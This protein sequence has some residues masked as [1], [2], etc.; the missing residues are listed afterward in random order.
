[1]TRDEIW[2][3]LNAHIDGELP[4]EA[5]VAMVRALERDPALARQ[6]ARLRQLK[7]G[8]QRVGEHRRQE[9]RR[10]RTKRDGRRSWPGWKPVT[11]WLLLVAMLVGAWP[12]WRY[13]MPG[14]QVPDEVKVAIG[15]DA[16]WKSALASSPHEQPVDYPGRSPAKRSFAPFIPDLTRAGFHFDSMVRLQ[17][18]RS[19]GLHVGYLGRHGC[20]VSLVIFPGQDAADSLVQTYDYQQVRVYTW[21]VS[22]TRYYLLAPDMDPQRLA[23]MA[24]VVWRLIR[25]HA[26][27]DDLS[28]ALLSQA[29]R[30]A[31]PC[32]A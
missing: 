24:R 8:L 17:S 32:S 25:R 29:R 2:R 14:K 12:A 11:L 16:A 22:H 27:L 20:R 26:P 28:L 31:M 13:L 6:A 30:Q 18:N 15:A 7:Q 10:R 19:E 1:M 9:R 3:Q 21:Q 5:A 4:P 23:G